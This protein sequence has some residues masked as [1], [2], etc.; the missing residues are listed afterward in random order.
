MHVKTCLSFHLIIFLLR[1]WVSHI[2]NVAQNPQHISNLHNISFIIQANSV[3][4]YGV[5]L[6]SEI[7]HASEFH[8]GLICNIFHVHVFWFIP[9]EIITF[10]REWIV[11]RDHREETRMVYFKGNLVEPFFY[12]YYYCLTIFHDYLVPLH[13]SSHFHKWKNL[14]EFVKWEWTKCNNSLVNC[15]I[16]HHLD[17]IWINYT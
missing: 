1:N 10:Y 2:I 14:S 11:A 9:L 3:A 16:T 13:V 8:F 15:I 17:H 7:Y 12:F 6:I 4:W 5:R